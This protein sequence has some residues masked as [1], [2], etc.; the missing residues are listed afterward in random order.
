MGKKVTGAKVLSKYAAPRLKRSRELPSASHSADAPGW[1]GFKSA[2]SVLR[3][4]PQ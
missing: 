1:L 3:S 2:Q 4:H